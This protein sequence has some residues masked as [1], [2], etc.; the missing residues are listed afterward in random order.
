MARKR[1]TLRLSPPGPA[2]PA[3][4]SACTRPAYAAVMPQNSARLSWQALLALQAVPR[5]HGGLFRQTRERRG[6]SQVDPPQGYH[7]PDVTAR[8]SSGNLAGTELRD[9]C[10]P[11]VNG[12]DRGEFMPPVDWQRSFST[13]QHTE[14][15]HAGTGCNGRR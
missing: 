7:A 12:G 15:R 11:D 10:R 8:G 13:L 9:Q 1:G 4:V 6:R 5:R 3:G 14:V 2:E